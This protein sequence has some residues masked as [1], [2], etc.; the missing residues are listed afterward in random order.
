MLMSRETIESIVRWQNALGEKDALMITFHGGEPLVPGISFYNMALPLLREG[1]APRKLRFSIQSNLWMLTDDLCKFFREY[2]VSIGT[3]LDGP[4]IINDAQRGKGYFQRTMAGIQLARTYGLNVSCICTF[5]AQSLPHAREIFDFFVSERL[6]FTIHAAVP[7]LRYSGATSWT[8]SPEAHGKLLVD[9]LDRYLANNNRV[10]I[11]TLDSLCSSISAGHGN[12]C[13]FVDCLG[14]HLTVGPDGDIYLCQRFGGMQEYKLSNVHNCPS[15]EVLSSSP[16]WRAFRD[17][18]ERIAEDCTDC[19]Y[20]DFCRG[21]CPYN[22][23]TSNGGRF[24]KRLRDP[25]CVAYK[26][27]FGYIMDRAMEE[28]FSDENLES[29]VT[30]GIIKHGLLHKGR[31]LQIMRGGLH[32]QKVL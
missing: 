27:I 8:L 13:T 22:A 12:I 30:N 20:L 24:E 16:V 11:K 14:K 15:L 32:Q 25:Q 7:T 19:T 6:N 1:L 5:T 3:S 21:G 28:I 26:I 17:R 23:P 29:I 2:N 9:M 10:R 18:E 4:E 31:L